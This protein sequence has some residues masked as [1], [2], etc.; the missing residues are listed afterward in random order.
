M[1][2]CETVVVHMLVQASMLLVV[3]E[4]KQVVTAT[5]H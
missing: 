3:V 2:Q 5:Y 1:V 4:Q